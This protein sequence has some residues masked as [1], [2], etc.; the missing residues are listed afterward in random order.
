MNF[1]LPFIVPDSTVKI[2]HRNTIV[3]S[4]SCFTE[5]MGSRL[6]EA[7]FKTLVNPQ[8]ILFNPLSI[9]SGLEFSLAQ[10]KYTDADIFLLNGVWSSWDFHSS[11]SNTS[12]DEALLSMN[13]SI[14]ETDDALK[15]AKFLIIT[16]GSAYQ[17]F[18]KAEYTEHNSAH[19]VANCHKAPGKWFDKK[20]LTVAEM[21]DPWQVV[22]DALQKVNP[23]L[24]VIFTVSPVRHYRDGLI[25]NNRS[26]ARLLELVH[27]LVEQHKHCQYFPAYEYVIDVLRDYRFFEEDMVHPNSQAA[28]Y[29]WERFTETYMDNNTADLLKRLKEITTAARHRE[30]F[31]G[32]EAS[33]KFRE[34]MLAK[35][36]NIQAEFPEL[37]LSAEIRF[38]SNIENGD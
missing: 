22:L 8:G 24:N 14:A 29:V 34:S 37:D 25:E 28:Q 30:R 12:M 15:T 27:T 5:H 21:L 23:E 10:K 31:P 7:K 11:F 6:K 19:G 18:L 17:Y 38:F 2:A 33:R 4:G 13:K 9:A 26:K 16:F 3:L 35:S 36:E 32:T 1:Q 20:L